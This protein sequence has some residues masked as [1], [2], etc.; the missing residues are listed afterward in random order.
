[1]SDTA[2]QYG[3]SDAAQSG[4]FILGGTKAVHRLGFGSMRTVGPGVLGPPRD[5]AEV[6]RTLRRLPELGVN[7][8]DTAD[9]YGPEIAERQIRE[10]LHP[11]P[12]M[13]IATK[14]GFLRP[15]PDEWKMH[16]DPKYLIER[17]HR[18]REILDVEII[19]LWQLHRIDPNVPEDEQFGAIRQ[20]LDEGVIALAGL[21]EVSVPQIQRAAQVFPVAS[22]QNRY[23]LVDRESEAVLEHCEAQGI[24]FIP[25]F[26]LAAGRLLRP[27]SGLQRIAAAHGATPGQ[28]ALAWLLQRSPVMLPIPGTSQRGHLEENVAAASIRLSRQEFDELDRLGRDAV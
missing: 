7:F 9:S 22:V 16:G 2:S 18:S 26:P 25:W 4:T 8:V 20:L 1:M 14:G 28:I 6:Q 17:A 15:G 11:Y 3:K 23:N 10:A 24:A 19:D 13:L 27:G 12:G 5:P 21:S